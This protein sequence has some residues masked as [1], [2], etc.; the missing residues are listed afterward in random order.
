MNTM[1]KLTDIYLNDD[2]TK[3][4]LQKLETYNHN[5]PDDIITVQKLAELFLDYGIRYLDVNAID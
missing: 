2:A 3:I 4:L 1:L 5:H